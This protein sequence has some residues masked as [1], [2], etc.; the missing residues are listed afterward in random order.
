M[1]VNQDHL[2]VENKRL[3]ARIHVLEE[4]RNP[5]TIR[6]ITDRLDNVIRMVNNHESDNYQVGQ[7]IND[8]QQ[9]VIALRQAIDAW[10]EQDPQ[11]VQD[12]TSEDQQGEQYQEEVI[13]LPV[14]EGHD[15]PDID[16]PG[17]SP[18]AS[19]AGSAA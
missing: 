13:R 2:I 18:S 14:N 17:L 19:M 8:I 5:T 3:Q 16:P 15:T 11:L 1:E 6:Q 7:S 4:S 10:N 12:P 9:E